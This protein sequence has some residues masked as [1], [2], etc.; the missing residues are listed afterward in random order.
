VITVRAALRVQIEIMLASTSANPDSLTPAPPVKS[1][2]HSLRFAGKALVQRTAHGSTHCTAIQKAG[3]IERRT[4]GIE[5]RYA[6]D[7]A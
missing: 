7:A 5:C 4:I 6:L 3:W 2:Q 1:R